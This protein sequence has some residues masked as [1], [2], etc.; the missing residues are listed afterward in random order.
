MIFPIII[1]IDYRLVH[2]NRLH[3]SRNFTLSALRQISWLVGI[4]RVT[5]RD[6]CW[7]NTLRRRRR[8]GT[9]HCHYGT[10][11]FLSK[12]HVQGGQ[13]HL[14]GFVGKEP[15]TA[16]WLYA[17]V[18]IRFKNYW[19][20][21]IHFTLSLMSSLFFFECPGLCGENEDGE[22]N[23]HLLSCYHGETLSLATNF[24]QFYVSSKD[25]L[26]Y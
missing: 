12:T 9:L 11:C 1:I 24:N 13:G 3:K 6:A 20:V 16:S 18:S 19:L 4:W 21:V 10:Q 5:L 8:R 14:Q 26:L 7:P 22:R 23:V 25:Y 17:N 2:H 15:K